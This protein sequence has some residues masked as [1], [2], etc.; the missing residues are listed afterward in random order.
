MCRVSAAYASVLS[1]VY[2]V[3][4]FIYAAL[5]APRPTK[6][7]WRLVL[8]YSSVVVC[9]KFLFQLSFLCVCYTASGEEYAVQPTCELETCRFEQVRLHTFTEF[10]QSHDHARTTFFEC[11]THVCPQTY[12]TQLGLTYVIGIYK[13]TGFFLKGSLWDVVLILAVLWHRHQMKMKAHAHLP[14]LGIVV[15]AAAA[16]VV[17][18]WSDIGGRVWCV[19]QGYWDLAVDLKQEF[20]GLQKSRK[21]WMGWLSLERQTHA[22]HRLPTLPPH[23]LGSSS[24]LPIAGIRGSRILSSR[25]S[26]LLLPVDLKHT[27]PADAPQGG[28]HIQ[29]WYVSC[30]CGDACVCVC[31]VCR[32]LCA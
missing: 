22:H 28:V 26:T 3:S 13:V 23:L 11:M 16:V 19:A 14:S 32:V 1:V 30:A 10:Q 31:G 2:P 20:K 8:A 27:L 18:V 25:H 12:D 6:T 29:E 9:V 5:A 24:M 21:Q 4:L 7:Y 17:V 15:V